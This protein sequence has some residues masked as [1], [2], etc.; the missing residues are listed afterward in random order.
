MGWNAA[1]RHK[2][3]RKWRR[4]ESL[5]LWRR[6]ITGKDVKDET[7]NRVGVSSLQKVVRDQICASGDKSLKMQ[8]LQLRYI[9]LKKHIISVTC[10]RCKTPLTVCSSLLL[11]SC[12]TS[13]ALCNF[14]I[15]ISLWKKIIFFLSCRV[16]PSESPSAASWGCS[17]CSSWATTTT[18]TRK[19]KR[20]RK[21]PAA[22][23]R[24]HTLPNKP[25][26]L[27][28]TVTP[29]GWT[30]LTSPLKQSIYSVTSV[31]S[32]SGSVHTSSLSN[33]LKLLA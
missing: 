22:T 29:A 4:K 31:S 25:L 30:L 8:H 19:R 24:R 26:Q 28:F 5:L 32:C 20:K 7:D 1:V 27:H 11:P 21:K 23:R 3:I 13:G 15:L 9:H 12:R 17:R 14:S 18:T 33:T 10:C 16:K 2:T 6:L